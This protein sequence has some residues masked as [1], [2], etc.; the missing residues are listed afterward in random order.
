VHT[1]TH[2]GPHNVNVSST[3]M[4]MNPQAALGGG[5]V[6]GTRFHGETGEWD[7]GKCRKLHQTY[8]YF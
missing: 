5:G 8:A 7:S 1:H 3:E 6:G 4:E 2:K